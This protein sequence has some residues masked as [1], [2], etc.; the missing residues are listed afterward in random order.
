MVRT[1][2]KRDAEKFAQTVEELYPDID[3]DVHMGGQPIYYYVL[4]SRVK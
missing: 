2:T 3:V 1:F 4:F